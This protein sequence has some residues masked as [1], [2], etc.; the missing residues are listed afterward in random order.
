MNKQKKLINMI[1]ALNAISLC[2]ALFL[3]AKFFMYSGK[4]QHWRMNNM[5]SQ[6]NEF[7]FSNILLL[8]F[9]FIVVTVLYKLRD[10]LTGDDEKQ[11]ADY[12][13]TIDQ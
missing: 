12:D 5:G 11:F 10:N 9:V 6:A 3:V 8:V 7:I 13:R 2:F 4:I 1:D